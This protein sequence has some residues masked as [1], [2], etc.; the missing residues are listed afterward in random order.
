MATDPEDIAAAQL[1]TPETMQKWTDSI[2]EL[3]Q[4]APGGVARMSNA[5]GISCAAGWTTLPFSTTDYADGLQGGPAG[6]GIPAT[7]YYQVSG[8]L[9]VQGNGGSQSTPTR[10]GIGLSTDPAKDPGSASAPMIAHSQQ[11]ILVP[12]DLQWPW[13]TITDELYCVAGQI[14]ALWFYHSTSAN[15]VVGYRKLTVRRVG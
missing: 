4:F 8:Q 6:V 12:T 13:L 7:G 2:R 15:V 3:Q 11:V 10:R 9:S 1:V 14:V 5:T